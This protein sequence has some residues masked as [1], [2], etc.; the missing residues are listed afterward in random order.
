MIEALEGGAGES[1]FHG[2][3]LVVKR[4]EDDEAFAAVEV[5]WEE[6]VSKLQR[7]WRFAT[8]RRPR[9]DYVKP[10]HKII[11]KQHTRYV[12]YPSAFP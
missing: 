8:Q 3:D 4:G 11:S 7:V 10:Y 12:S 2:V 5:L 1:F 6:W 9:M